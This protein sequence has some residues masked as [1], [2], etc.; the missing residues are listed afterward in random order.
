MSHI[1]M[2]CTFQTLQNALQWLDNWELEVE[3]GQIT[4]D[5]FLTKSTSEGLRVTILSTI[6][7][8]NEL[9]NTYNFTYVLTSKMNQDRLEV[10]SFSYI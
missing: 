4:S 7:L 5:Q 1:T 2:R 3:N 10:N 8:C 9:L 6:A